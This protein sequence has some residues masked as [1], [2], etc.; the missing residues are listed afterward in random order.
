MAERCLR[1]DVLAIWLLSSVR[2]FIDGVL[3]SSWKS[4]PVSLND[5]SVTYYLRVTE[6]SDDL[7]WGSAQDSQAD[8]YS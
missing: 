8:S 6:Q 3:L 4:L 7:I 1:Q 2:K 5:I